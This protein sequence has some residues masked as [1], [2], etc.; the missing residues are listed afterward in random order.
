MY[1]AARNTAREQFQQ[2]FRLT[3]EF[4]GFFNFVAG[5]AYYE[6]NLDFVVF[7]NLGFVD[8]ISPAGTS[9]ALQFANVAEIQATSQDRESRA[10]YLDTTFDFT[11]QVKLTLG[12]RRSEDEKKFS[13]QQYL[14]LIHI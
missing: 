8:L 11:D 14:S 6:D 5:A 3:S 2:E 9:A 1:D 10:I 13:R 4:D 12:V 7:G